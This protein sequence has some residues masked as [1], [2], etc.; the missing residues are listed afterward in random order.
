MVCT[1]DFDISFETVSCTSVDKPTISEYLTSDSINKSFLMTPVVML[2]VA[3]Q[4]HVIAHVLTVNVLVTNASIAA[5]LLKV[6]L[7]KV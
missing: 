4:I 2:K 6:L 1:D 3:T 7:G 5:I